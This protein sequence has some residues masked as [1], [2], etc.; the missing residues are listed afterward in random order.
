MFQCRRLFE[1]SHTV[2]SAH[3][4][5]F[6]AVKELPWCAPVGTPNSP[7]PLPKPISRFGIVAAM[8]RN[9]VIGI[10]GALP[11]RL[12]HDRDNFLRLTQDK[13]LIVGRRTLEEAPNLGHVQ[14]ARCSVVVSKALMNSHLSSNG[15]L[16]VV[17]SF[18]AALVLARE[19]EDSQPRRP[20]EK[21]EISCWVA[22]GERIYQDAL[23]HP[24]AQEVRLTVVDTDVDISDAESVAFFPPLN[25]VFREADRQFCNDDDIPFTSFVYTRQDGAN[26]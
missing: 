23:C 17:P 22:G 26:S 6:A 11:W 9:R 5:A 1:S 15:L 16:R 4:R 3:S 12:P 25:Q 14:H 13:I 19:L 18:E 2:H 24:S 20:H 7:K 8:S 10:D 21:D